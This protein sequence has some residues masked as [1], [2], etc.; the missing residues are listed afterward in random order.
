MVWLFSDHTQNNGRISKKSTVFKNKGCLEVYLMTA[1]SAQFRKI[2]FIFYSFSDFNKKTDIA[3]FDVFKEKKFKAMQSLKNIPQVI[4]FKGGHE[5]HYSGMKNFQS[6][7]Q[8]LEK[9][10]DMDTVQELHSLEDFDA[11]QSKYKS[12]FVRFIWVFKEYLRENNL[13]IKY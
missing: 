11:I 6:I 2:F 3:I 13:F 12:F 9:K 1:H 5:I 7:F 8:F 10:L 4:L